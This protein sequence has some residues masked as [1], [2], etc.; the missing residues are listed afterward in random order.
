MGLTAK[1]YATGFLN[2]C[3]I[4]VSNVWRHVFT[5]IYT[6]DI[7]YVRGDNMAKMDKQDTLDSINEQILKLKEKKKALQENQERE[8]GKYLLKTWDT[9]SLNLQDIFNLIDSH[10]PKQINDISDPAFNTSSDV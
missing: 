5:Y 7:L 10:K 2:P 8:I 9:S 3:H 6:Y 1:E 4:E